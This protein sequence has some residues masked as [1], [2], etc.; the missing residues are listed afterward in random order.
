MQKLILGGTWMHWWTKRLW[1]IVGW[2][3]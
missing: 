3:T 1:Q 2:V